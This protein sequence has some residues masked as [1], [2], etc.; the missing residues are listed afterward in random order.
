M[1][2]LL[3]LRALLRHLPFCLRQLRLQPIGLAMKL[4][5]L[6]LLRAKPLRE[7]PRPCRQLCPTPLKL[8]SK[9]LLRPHLHILHR[10][11]VPLQQAHRPTQLRTELVAMP[12]RLIQ[13]MAR[14]HQPMPLLLQLRALLRHFPFC[15]R[16]LRLQPIGLAMKLG[17]LRLLRAKPLR[18]RLRPPRHRH[19]L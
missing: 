6:R 17:K 8:L 2:L 9:R 1:P 7:R 19:H 5:Q 11:Q 3:Q 4:G 15:L 14:R 16:Q 13:L 10:L 18:E 12:H